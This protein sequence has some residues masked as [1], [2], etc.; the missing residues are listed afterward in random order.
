MNFLS[1]I[2]AT[3]MVLASLSMV[4]AGKAPDAAVTHKV[5][6]DMSTC[7]VAN[8]RDDVARGAPCPS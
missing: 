5:F 6:F 2:L 8:D 7:F 3:I 4:S 1:S